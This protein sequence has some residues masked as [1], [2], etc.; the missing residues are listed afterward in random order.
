M[1][2]NYFE[3]QNKC[4]PYFEKSK[5]RKQNELNLPKLIKNKLKSNIK[6]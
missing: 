1:F 3:K 4:D 2:L 5:N 6:Q